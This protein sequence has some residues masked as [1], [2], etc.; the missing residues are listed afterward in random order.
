MISCLAS[1]STIITISLPSKAS[2]PATM[3]N[4]LD[5]KSKEA[6]D[7]ICSRLRLCSRTVHSQNYT[8]V[9][10]NLKIGCAVLR[11]A[12]NVRIWLHSLKIAQVPRLCK[13]Y[14]MNYNNC[15]R[16]IHLLFKFHTFSL[17]PSPLKVCAC[18]L[19][20]MCLGFGMDVLAQLETRQE[21]LQWSNVA[22]PNSFADSFN[23]A[24]VFGML[25]F[26]TIIYMLLAW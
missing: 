21:G 12:H 1:C 19:N 7:S 3:A 2:D 26:D 5:S 23:M 17:I 13:T 15:Y 16:F 8:S 20:N 18:I 10:C 22:S 25:A 4:Q 6:V 24:W 9:L 14:Y 11:L